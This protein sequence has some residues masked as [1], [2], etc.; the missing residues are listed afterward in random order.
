MSEN[1]ETQFSTM[2]LT[3]Y[4]RIKG[5]SIQSVSQTFRRHKA[6]MEGMYTKNGRKTML[7]ESGVKFLDNIREQLPVPVTDPDTLTAM[8]DRIRILESQLEKE[9]ESNAAEMQRKA[10]RIRDLEQMLDRKEDLIDEKDRIITLKDSQY[11]MLL[12]L[13]AKKKGVFQGMREFFMGTDENPL[14]GAGN[15]R[16]VDN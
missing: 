3:D 16:T 14:P 15:D 5:I 10:D 9:R 13:T 8:K 1:N 11:Q 12:Q 4:A 7:T 2:S 6:E